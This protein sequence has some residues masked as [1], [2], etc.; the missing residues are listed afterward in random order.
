MKTLFAFL[1]P[2]DTIPKQSFVRGRGHSGFAFHLGSRNADNWTALCGAE[3]VE[4]KPYEE[5]QATVQDA[6]DRGVKDY[7]PKCLSKFLPDTDAE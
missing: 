1:K 7:C 3:M 4:K 5:T 6:L 2:R